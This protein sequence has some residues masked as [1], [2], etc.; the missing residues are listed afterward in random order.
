[1][2]KTCPYCHTGKLTLKNTYDYW[3]FKHDFPNLD[4]GL[5]NVRHDFL[6]GNCYYRRYDCDGCGHMI[7]SYEEIFHICPHKEKKSIN[8]PGKIDIYQDGQ[9]KG[10]ADIHHYS[11]DVIKA[12]V[13]DIPKGLTNEEKASILA[14][15]RTE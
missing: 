3:N 8:T 10:Q 13:D 12:A 14:K 15:L 4:L 1:M 11:T 7:W 5:R 9:Y 6:P 2:K